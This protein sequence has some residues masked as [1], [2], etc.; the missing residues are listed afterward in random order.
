MVL[1]YSNISERNF[2]TKVF[3]S[4]ATDTTIL[5]NMQFIF[6]GDNFVQLIFHDIEAL[7]FIALWQQCRPVHAVFFLRFRRA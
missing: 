5:L 7:A 3:H 1:L 6:V 4:F 2:I